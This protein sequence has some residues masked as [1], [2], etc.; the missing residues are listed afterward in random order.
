MVKRKEPPYA[1]SYGTA[2]ILA[3][4]LD[5]FYINKFNLNSTLHVA[6]FNLNLASIVKKSG[7][8]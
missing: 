1:L 8:N 6:I 3:L 2:V 7:K 4:F 5:Y